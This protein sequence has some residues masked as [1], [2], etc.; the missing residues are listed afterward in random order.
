MRLLRGRFLPFFSVAAVLVVSGLLW[1]SNSL[2]QRLAEDERERME[3]YADA[4]RF[5]A[6]ND[7]A[8][9]EFLYNH[10][11][12]EDGKQRIFTSPSIM[13]DAAGNYLGDNLQL[14]DELSDEE[15]QAEVMRQLE[16][17]RS[18]PE[19]PPIVV[20]YFPGQFNYIYYRES[21]VLRQLRYYPYVALF[22]T[23][24][25]MAAAAY[26]SIVGQRNLQ[27]HVWAGLAKETAHQLGT[28]ISGLLAWLELM[29]EQITKTE[30]RALV[31][32]MEKDVEQLQRIAERFSKIGS[33]PELRYYR[34]AEVLEN[35]TEYARSR[36]ASKSKISVILANDLPS[37]LLVPMNPMLI[38]WVIENLMKNALDALAGM[39]GGTIILRAFTA[40]RHKVAIEVE[41]TGKGIARKHMK[42]VFK[43]GF[44]TKKRGW[45]L[46][47]SLSKRIV[48]EYHRGRI[49]V[50]KSELGKGTTFRLVLP[51]QPPKKQRQKKATK[52]SPAPAQPVLEAV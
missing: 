9:T 3:F 30:N 37:Q 43:P 45:G 40:G 51:A 8:E 49:F 23:L 22:I 4:I 19:L 52:A 50:R 47:L 10:I 12:R 14:P 15:R 2:I 21:W 32:E 1:Y 31:V 44:T 25:F 17:M 39:E 6:T 33:E 41:D 36:L 5:I 20:E 7:N 48:H 24:A 11:L 46:G 34:L 26:N 18:D 13:T 35:A 27:N 29:K 16:I 38:S 28:P 42:N